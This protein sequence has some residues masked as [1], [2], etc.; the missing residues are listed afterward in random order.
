MRVNATAAVS[1]RW[2]DP[3]YLSITW[4]PGDAAAREVNAP[5]CSAGVSEDD[6]LCWLELSFPQRMVS[7]H[8]S[9][10]DALK[11]AVK[12]ADSGD[13]VRD[14]AAA[15]TSSKYD[16]EADVLFFVGSASEGALEH[17][18]TLG[19]DADGK[20]RVSRDGAQTTL[21]IRS[22]LAGRPVE[23]RRCYA[24]Y[25]DLFADR[26]S[27]EDEGD[28]APLVDVL[29]RARAC[30]SSATH[31]GLTELVEKLSSWVDYEESCR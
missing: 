3:D 31:L 29:E 17:P 7:E 21:V 18:E 6:V 9:A 11:S 25:H 30:L 26:W 23:A 1:I 19:F 15:A 8:F 27:R 4:S 16:P 20:V 13:L 22:S 2:L 14:A 24:E 28:D 5:G 12:V 10:D